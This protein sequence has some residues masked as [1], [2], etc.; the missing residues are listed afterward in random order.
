[1]ETCQFIII[2]QELTTAMFNLCE[3]RIASK[4]Y[5]HDKERALMASALAVQEALK[6][7]VAVDLTI[8]I[9]K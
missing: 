6:A 2:T 4:K 1:M 8:Q 9:D 3:D 7:F 5:S